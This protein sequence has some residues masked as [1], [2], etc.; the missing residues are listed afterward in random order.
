MDQKLY[1]YKAPHEIAFE[2][3]G[4][5]IGHPRSSKDLVKASIHLNVTSET[6]TPQKYKSKGLVERV[7]VLAEIPYLVKKVVNVVAGTKPYIYQV[8]FAL[9]SINF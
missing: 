9:P 7:D 3:S 5:P 2:W 6:S 8:S 4:P 1:R